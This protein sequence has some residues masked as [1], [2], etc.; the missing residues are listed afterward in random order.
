MREKRAQHPNLFFDGQIYIPTETRR[1]TPYQSYLLMILHFYT[2][3]EGPKESINN[4]YSV[5]DMYEAGLGNLP[6]IN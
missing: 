4:K 2:P 6:T 1:V 3:P 5:F